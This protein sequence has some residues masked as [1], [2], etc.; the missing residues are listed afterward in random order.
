M[1]LSHAERTHGRFIAAEAPLLPPVAAALGMLAAWI[2]LRRQRIDLAELAERNDYL[3]ED[4][5]VS[6]GDALHEAAKP[7]WAR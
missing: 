5:G 2:A 4:I 3:L 1:T 7:F 6:R